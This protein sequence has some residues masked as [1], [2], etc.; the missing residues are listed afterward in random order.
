MGGTDTYNKINLLWQCFKESRAPEMRE[1][2]ILFYAPMVRK[3]VGRMGLRPAGA[4]EWEDLLNYGVF[5]LMDAVERFEPE[6]GINFET[7]A[8]LRVR[9]AVLDALRQQDPLGRL[10]R[11][12][13]RA[14]KGAIQQLSTELGRPPQDSEVAEKTGLSQNQYKHT[15]QDAHLSI[16]SL[17][18]PTYNNDG[19]PSSLMDLLED[20][21]AAAMMDRVEEDEMHERLLISLQ[22]LSRREQTLLSLYYSEELTMR[23]VAEVMQI[24]QTRVCQIHARAIL[25]LKALMAPP[26]EIA[27]ESDSPVWG[28]LFNPSDMLSQTMEE[29]MFQPKGW[30]HPRRHSIHHWSE[31]RASR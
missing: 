22:R 30:Q 8:N 7:F 21:E 15:R 9:G 31:N 17:D 3:V 12:R 4:I 11:Q 16:L 23:E 6:R 5:G 2:L 19:Q 29:R 13:V 27:G 26:K 18:Q 1:K 10:A 28:E 25:A 20:P 24:S 14:V